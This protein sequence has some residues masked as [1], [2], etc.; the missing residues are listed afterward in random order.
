MTRR[1]DL[2]LD[3]MVGRINFDQAADVL[4]LSACFPD[5]AMAPTSDLSYETSVGAAE[6]CTDLRDGMRTGEGEVVTVG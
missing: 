3:E 4:E 2:P 6:D 5:D 1:L